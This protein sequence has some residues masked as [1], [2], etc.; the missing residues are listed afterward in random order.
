M[1][2]R[3]ATSL[4]RGRTRSAA[5][6]D[7]CRPG[8]TRRNFSI[9]RR[10][11]RILRSVTE[12]ANRY[13]TAIYAVDPRGLAPFE[14]DLST[15][16][17]ANVSLT[18][19]RA[20]L[21]NTMDTLRILA[22]ETDGRA[23]VNSNDL[24]KGLRQIVRDSS[25]YYLLGYTSTLSQPD[26]KFHKINVRVKRPGLQL[27]ARPGYLAMTA[28]EAERATAN[29]EEGGSARRR[30]RSAR[31]AR[32]DDEAESDPKLDRNVARRERQDQD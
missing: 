29:D 2:G 16:G 31:H 24:D 26:G 21:E 8:R 17:S 19:D 18:K 22:D 3:A 13:N 9:R 15:Q 4:D 32:R 27:R 14:F 6:V 28:V 30:H 25:A 7:L 1:A 20:M 11:G 23:I 5:R 10:S 12:L